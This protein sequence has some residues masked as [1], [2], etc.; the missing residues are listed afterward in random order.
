M[1]ILYVT[2]GLGGGGKE[3]QIVEIIT[4]LIACEFVRPDNL[5]V[6]CLNG[7]TFYSGLLEKQGVRIETLCGGPKI[8]FGRLL[9]FE[10]VRRSFH[11]AIIHSFSVIGTLFS[12]WPKLI[13]SS[14][15]IDGSIR[16]APAP[17]AVPRKIRAINRFNYLFADAVVANSRSGLLS[18]QPPRQK[19]MVIHNGF[20]FER[21]A[22]LVPRE[23][24]KTDLGIKAEK[25]IGMVANFF[26][27]KDY[28]T[29]L[30][31]AQSLLEERNDL[32]FLTIGYGSLLEPSQRSV[33]HRYRDRIRFLGQRED[34]ESL[35]NLFD[36]AV[37]T[38]R[39]E[40][41]SN[42]IMEYM[43][44]GKPVIATDCDGN[45]EVIED[46][47]SG[48]LIRPADV[49]GLAAKISLLLQDEGL[50]T[51]MGQAGALRIQKG[52]S[53]EKMISTYCRL[54]AKLGKAAPSRNSIITDLPS[55][56]LGRIRFK[57]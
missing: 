10:Q 3:R 9:R 46:G 16:S 15:L 8:G 5:R 42:S 45:R 49:R 56:P 31:A 14:R 43:A 41:I 4:G 20:N 55:D 22:H 33:P 21:I 30:L 47:V 13:H 17:Q 23:K 39:G 52:F 25:V 51:R 6:L 7:E 12:V 1:N 50:K 28:D 38:T 53:L 18:F 54:Y 44:L 34:V 35:V 26:P 36:L 29:F 32:V 2:D 19:S 48:F 37:L 57:R 27:A 24:L 40:G 11:P